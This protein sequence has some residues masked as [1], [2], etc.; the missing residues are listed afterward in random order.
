M[1]LGTEN[2]KKVRGKLINVN[3]AWN[4]E[5]EVDIS[6]KTMMNSLQ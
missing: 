2:D 3:G 4:I 1:T 6:F 5:L